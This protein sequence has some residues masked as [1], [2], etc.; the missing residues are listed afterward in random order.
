MKTAKPPCDTRAFDAKVFRSKKDGTPFYN[1]FGR[2][3]PRGGRKPRAPQ[4][5]AAPVPS[6]ATDQPQ[7]PSQPPTMPATPAQPP[8]APAP[9]AA[10]S[11]ADIDA[12]ADAPSPFADPL[13]PAAP[14][15]PPANIAADTCIGIIQTAFVMVGD[16][17]GLL[18]DAEKAMLRRPLQRVL[19]KYNVGEKML[20]AELDLAVA[21]A[22]L[23]IVRLKK[24]KTATWFVRV[25]AW[26]TNRFF[27]AKGRSFARQMRREVPEVTPPPAATTAIAPDA[28]PTTP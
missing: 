27:G 23:F 26:V 9:F 16:D 6:A 28:A 15:E 7:P 22:T 1:R 20:P 3:M 8:S 4:P 17:E 10:P 18:S 12:A 5:P 2:Y 19:D 13:K 25:K 24:P 21:V 11:F 14:P